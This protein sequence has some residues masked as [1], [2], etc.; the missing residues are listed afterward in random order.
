MVLDRIVRWWQGRLRRRLIY[1]QG[2][3]D[4]ENAVW[5]RVEQFASVG[6]PPGSLVYTRGYRDGCDRRLSRAF[7]WWRR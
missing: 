6:C 1:R 3:D 4:G 2:R 5:P 7:P